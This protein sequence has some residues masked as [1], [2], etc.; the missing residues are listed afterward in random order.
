VRERLSS[1]ALLDSGLFDRAAIETLVSQH[2]SGA[3]DHNQALWSLLMFEGWH[4][5]VHTAPAAMPVARDAA[6][7][8]AASA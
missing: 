5:S 1:A 8:V 2:E 7:R 4:K 6:S 3:F